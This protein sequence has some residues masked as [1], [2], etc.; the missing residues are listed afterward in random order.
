MRIILSGGG[1]WDGVEF[2]ADVAPEEI[3]MRNYVDSDPQNWQQ[4]SDA[5]CHIYVRFDEERDEDTLL[6][7]EEDEVVYY[8]YWRGENE[9]WTIR[10]DESHFM[11]EFDES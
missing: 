3:R 8:H 1:V 4:A 9:R 10:V 6:L 2:M 5:T 7:T 11:D